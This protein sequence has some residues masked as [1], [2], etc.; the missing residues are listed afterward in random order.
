M[1]VMGLGVA[2]V[3]LCGIG[4][5]PGD[6]EAFLQC[7]PGVGAATRAARAGGVVVLHVKMVGYQTASCRHD[8]WGV[9][10][11]AH[12]PNAV[13]VWVWV[14][15]GLGRPACSLLWSLHKRGFSLTLHCRA[16]CPACRTRSPWSPTAEL[17]LK[18]TRRMQET[19][20]DR[21]LGALTSTGSGVYGGRA[22]LQEDSGRGCVDGQDAP[23]Q[24]VTRPRSAPARGGRVTHESAVLPAAKG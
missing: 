5:I 2:C 22:P 4:S 11:R 3:Y 16:C 17:G 15:L 8:K 12:V 9:V 19:E 6:E 18:G 20:S 10:T 7:G 1:I 14:E 21:P 13:L 23:D 24:V